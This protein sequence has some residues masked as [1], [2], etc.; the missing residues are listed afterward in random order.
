MQAMYM[1]ASAAGLSETGEEWEAPGVQRPGGDWG[2]RDARTYSRVGWPI[3]TDTA[4]G[5]AETY[6]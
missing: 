3:L 2:P 4:E 6:G 5:M 1:Y